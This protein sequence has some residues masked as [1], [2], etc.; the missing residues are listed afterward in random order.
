MDD[1]FIAHLS[2]DGNVQ[3]VDAHLCGVAQLCGEF[4]S[5]FSSSKWGNAL[6][7]FHDIGKYSFDFQEYLRKAVENSKSVRRG[8]VDHSS[9]GAILAKKKGFYAI[10]YAIAGHHGGLPNS[11]RLSAR[12]EKISEYKKVE[13][14]LPDFVQNMERPVPPLGLSPQS[15][16]MWARL[17]FSSLVDADWLDTEA[18]YSGGRKSYFDNIASL[19]N[20]LN[21]YMDALS[22]K[23]SKS[24]LNSD[25]NEIFRKCVDAGISK[26]GNFF[27]LTVPTGY[28]KTL[29]SMAF[30][31]NYALKHNK[32]R[33]IVAIPFT[34]IIAQS[35][36]IFREIFGAKNVLEHH[37][38]VDFSDGG[39]VPLQVRFASENWDI[40]IVLT[41]NV[42]F[43]ET[44]YASAASKCRRLHN[45]CESVVVLD[46][47]QTFP[48]EFLSP[49]LEGMKELSDLG[50]TAFLFCS[51]TCPTFFG[52]IGSGSSGFDSPLPQPTEI[53]ENYEELFSKSARAKI[54]VSPSEYTYD[55]IADKLNSRSVSW[56]CITNTR[57]RAKEIASRVPDAFHLSRSMCS[58]H[59]ADTLEKVRKSLAN[60]EVVK[61][62]ST[63][64]IEAGVD[65]DFPEV[66]REF[67]GLDSVVQAAG[68][69]NREG[70]IKS[71]EVEVFRLSGAQN[72]G[73]I[74][75]AVSAFAELLDMG[76]IGDRLDS[77]GNLARYFKLF[78]GAIGDFD[79]ADIKGKLWSCVQGN[80]LMFEFEDA[81]REF[82][83]IDDED[84]ESVIVPYASEGGS[85]E[86][87]GILDEIRYGR[88]PPYIAARKL[89]RFSVQVRGCIISRLKS[90]GA[91][92][93]DNTY[94]FNILIDKSFYDYKYGLTVENN[95]ND[96]ILIA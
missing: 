4:A 47:V 68:R 21:S 14:H 62:V 45:V 60:G 5:D 52:R 13:A 18:F 73:F 95:F 96:D 71:G 76:N 20:R 46:E 93:A 78:Y 82:R 32:K 86:V 69:C 37:S 40:P 75:K 59:I 87:C 12:I 57:S 36:A 3:T 88:L 94:G 56:L 58:A 63:Q 8:E 80:R 72:V 10:D 2:T 28:G 7:L 23:A 79:K 30:A 44:F 65:I 11:A 53:I 9:A 41:T 27:S 64:L 85:S 74:G 24:L 54:S 83:L 6:G 48:P 67:A 66:Y 61:L 92:Y 25:R 42:R 19:L 91:V 39:A 31:L 29:S 38:G 35:A 43:F 81:A 15:L 70:R 50:G 26:N 55:S 51:A 90:L 34:G 1:G 84:G 22:K 33:V 17:L 49:I 89:Q 16:N 77:P